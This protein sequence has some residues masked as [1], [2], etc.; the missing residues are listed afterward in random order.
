MNQNQVL[1]GKASID[2]PWMKFYP[3]EVQKLQIPDSTLNSYL[4]QRCVSKE[5]IAIHYYGTDISWAEFFAQAD[6][7]AKALKALGF[8]VGDQIPVFLRSVPEF[9]LLLLAAE[10][11]GARIV[12]R[13]NL[14][15]ENAEAVKN[16]GASV[17]IA[18][19][20]ISQEDITAIEGAGAR[21]FVLLSPYQSADRAQ[22]PDYIESEIQALYGDAREFTAET[23]DWEQFLALGDAY[24][25]EYL[26]EIDID[27]PLYSAYTSGSTG[28]SK[29]VIHSAHTMIGII[30]QMAFYGSADSFRPVWLVTI[31]PPCLI[32]VVNSMLLM[33][34]AS[35]KLLVLDPFCSVNDIDLEMMRYRPNGW[36]LI[37]M[38]IEIL[39]NSKRI[40]EDYDI[41]HLFAVGA[42]CESF[43]NG[44]FKRAQKFIESH[45]GKALVTV[46]YG[47]SE[48]GSNCIFP[49][50]M[51][52]VGNGVVG[53]PMP[54]NNTGIFKPGTQEE[55]GYLE[56]GEI[57]ISSPGL[58]L[59]YDN[60]VKTAEVLQKHEDG[61]MWLH[62][63]DYGYMDENGV[64]YAFGRGNTNRFGGGYLSEI[65]ME[66]RVV[67][68]NIEGLRDNFFVIIE[69]KEHPGFYEPYLYVVLEEGVTIDDIKG[70]IYDALNDFERPVDIIQL[71]ERPFFH[72]KTNRVGLAK[73]L[74]ARCFINGE[75]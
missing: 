28:T 73:E 15:H 39:M 71:P 33:P 36:P 3:E 17:V 10:K 23:M 68:A 50:P 7:I 57:C 61:C 75:T 48:A 43:N 46:G 4:E 56:L 14:P 8:G 47:M 53:M 40:P 20:F 67:D 6:R 72:F 55:L 70:K 9:L 66:N 51:Y 41:S 65:F 32:A 64:I 38:F 35:N 18:H 12:C 74:N 24:E 52:P 54:L 2:R 27:R 44:Q 69:D 29:Q 16:A 13:D 49:N 60:P 11:I 37:P 62:T 21:R 22:I 34:M 31:L 63:G 45:N 25:G 19:D 1:T 30:H 5:N 58:M 59:G 42:G 26:A